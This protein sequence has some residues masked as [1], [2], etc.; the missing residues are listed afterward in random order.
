MYKNLTVWFISVFLAIFSGFAFAQQ[1][2]EIVIDIFS[3][4]GMQ[5]NG[6]TSG[7]SGFRTSYS[8]IYG[9]NTGYADYSFQ[10]FGNPRDAVLSVQLS[11]EYS[12]DQGPR[13]HF[14]DIS[15]ILNGEI[16]STVHVIPDNSVGETY[17]IPLKK[18]SFRTGQNQI[19]F[20][21][22][23]QS[24]YRNGLVIYATSGGNSRQ[25]KIIFNLNQTEQDT[26]LNPSDSWRQ[27]G[28]ELQLRDVNYSTNRGGF[29]SFALDFT[30]N[31]QVPIVFRYNL[32]DLVKIFDVNS[33]EYQVKFGVSIK[34]S[35]FS[36]IV[37]PGNTV[38]LKCLNAADGAVFLDILN[39]QIRELVIE[40]TALSSIQNARWLIP[41]PR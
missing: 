38:R 30:N 29:V 23:P 12:G 2:E 8:G 37:N 20:A 6:P 9:Q 39:P 15:I 31:K 5:W 32:S 24:Q 21:V 25:M 11:S 40:V 1:S 10:M 28:A 7:T 13:D 4:T 19:R 35:T 3:S 16:Q 14:S 33:N 27:E 41:M 17:L 22:L 18:S 34:C 36:T 26:I